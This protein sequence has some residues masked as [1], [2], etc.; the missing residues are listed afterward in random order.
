MQASGRAI[1]SITRLP[2]GVEI[3]FFDPARAETC[4]TTQPALT[5]LKGAKRRNG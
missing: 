1:S 4:R 2:G 3:R 5:T